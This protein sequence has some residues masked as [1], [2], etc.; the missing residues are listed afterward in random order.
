MQCSG[1]LS[2]KL[3]AR[4]S[5]LCAA[6]LLM[7]FLDLRYHGEIKLKHHLIISEAVKLLLRLKFSI[8]VHLR[9]NFSKLNFLR[10]QLVWCVLR[11][12]LV[13]RKTL[14]QARCF[15]IFPYCIQIDN[16]HA[17]SL[18]SRLPSEDL[19]FYELFELDQ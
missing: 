5:S 18:S 12:I 14:I 19:Q 7:L 16:D 17:L 2:H 10:N 11:S 9:I 8:H 6:F 13:K 4:H 15:F 1:H 3:F